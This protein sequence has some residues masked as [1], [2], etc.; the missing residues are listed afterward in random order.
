M[1]FEGSE[2]QWAA[3][4]IDNKE[5]KDKQISTPFDNSDLIEAEK[6]FN[7]IYNKA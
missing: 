7:A 5:Y 4:E 1:Y 6:H 2:E 3:I